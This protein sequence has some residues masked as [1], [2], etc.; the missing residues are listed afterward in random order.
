[1][2]NITP[3]YEKYFQDIINVHTGEGWY[4][5]DIPTKKSIY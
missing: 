4:K 1:M 2:K 3:K 5:T